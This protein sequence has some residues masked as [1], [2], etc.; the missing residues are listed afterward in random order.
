MAKQFLDL[1]GLKTVWNQVETLDTANKAAHIT[2]VEVDENATDPTIVDND[3]QIGGKK[4]VLPAFGGAEVDAL[5]T[6]VDKI[7]TIVVGQN[8]TY[9]GSYSPSGAKDIGTLPI[10][11]T[12]TFTGGGAN[13]LDVTDADVTERKII[14]GG[15][16]QTVTNSGKSFSAKVNFPAAADGAISASISATGS[17][18]VLGIA[19]SNTQTVSAYSPFYFLV[20]DKDVVPTGATLAAISATSG[21]L[22]SSNPIKRIASS[23]GNS[24]FVTSIPA[25]MALYVACPGNKV[26]TNVGTD[27]ADWGV[28]EIVAEDVAVDKR[29][30]YKIYKV[31]YVDDPASAVNNVTLIFK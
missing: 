13:G 18:K 25:G 15:V 30:N 5:Q 3:A 10:E 21:A 11:I 12:F 28:G 26:L 31:T 24:S 17:A 16:E 2:G 14:S 23:V 8:V 6:Q 9:T 4:I 7:S 20:A 1:E 22:T 19:K 27:K 29:G